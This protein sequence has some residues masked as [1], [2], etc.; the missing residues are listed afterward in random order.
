LGDVSVRSSYK[1]IHDTRQTARSTIYSLEV[2]LE[3]SRVGGISVG[4]ASRL[5]LTVWI[6]VR[7]AY[8]ARELGNKVSVTGARKALMTWFTGPR[9]VSAVRLAFLRIGVRL[10]CSCWLGRGSAYAV[11]DLR[12]VFVRTGVRVSSPLCRRGR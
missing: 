11:R 3:K 8:G 5:S 4:P 7:E 12:R 9:S 1:L 10:V 6:R 2:E